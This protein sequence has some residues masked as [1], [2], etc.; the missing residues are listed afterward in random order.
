[1]VLDIKARFSITKFRVLSNSMD[2]PRPG[3]IRF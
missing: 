3:A 2:S 1:M